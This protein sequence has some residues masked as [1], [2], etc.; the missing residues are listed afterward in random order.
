MKVSTP[1]RI[2]L[3]GEHQDYLNLPV[4]AAA[5]SLRM[6]IEGG[7]RG[8]RQIIINMPDINRIESINLDLP[9]VYSQK[10]DYFKSSI[11]VLQ[12]LGF[13]FSKGMECTL[14]SNIP[15]NAGTSS[16]SAM[17]VSW[18]NFLS[19]M[20]DQQKV[21]SPHQL[22]ELAY[23]AEVLEFNEAGGMMDQYSTSIGGTI[24]IES[25]PEIKTKNYKNIPGYFIL[26][27]SREPK[28]TQSILSRVKGGVLDI[29]V[30][31]KNFDNNF[32]LHTVQVNELK[33]YRK[34]LQDSEYEL[35]SGTIINRDITR[36][37]D[38]L[39]SGPCIDEKL[40]GQLLTEHQIILRDIQKISTNK[41]DK[42][43]DAA[44]EAGALGAKINGS[45]GGG[46]MFAYASANAE[47]VCEAIKQ[48]SGEAYIINISEG[49]KIE[50]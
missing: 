10:K 14:R 27:N 45:G 40:F 9:L 38:A 39:L 23:R 41:I 7:I 31:L 33:K 49:T 20:S 21:L 22:A 48:I 46:C 25:L 35:L 32:L 28:D 24:W 5:V 1:G 4:I 42:M 3:F 44:L 2:C 29:V 26:G 16:S 11:K 15:I 18:L 37:A 8:D 12:G 34:L 47:N 19:R 6:Q 36:K 30:K 43:I 50:M 13:T 17:V